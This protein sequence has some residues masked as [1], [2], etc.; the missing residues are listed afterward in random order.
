MTIE[1]PC[2][3]D[4]IPDGDDERRKYE[5]RKGWHTPDDCPRAIELQGSMDLIFRH[6]EEG[7]A[8]IS[9]IETRI[10]ENN[11]VVAE[12]ME[13]LTAKQDANNKVTDEIAEILQMGKGFFKVIWVT[14]K[15][16]R[17]IILW[18]APVITAVI[19]MWYAITNR[20]Q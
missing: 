20:P 17:R 14:G 6:F 2:I 4:A 1:I 16:A 15:W 18:V 8:R 19:S 5:R 7:N 10:E 13:S 3:D 12:K 11:R 9:A